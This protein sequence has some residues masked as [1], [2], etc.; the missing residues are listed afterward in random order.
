MSTIEKRSSVPAVNCD[1]N[2][3]QDQIAHPD[4][5]NKLAKPSKL[6]FFYTFLLFL[7]YVLLGLDISI[8]GI[9]L[10]TLAQNIGISIE[11]VSTTLI[12]RGI[13]FLSG[14]IVSGFL[15]GK[16]NDFIIII[17]SLLIKSLGLAL[18]PI[19]FGTS[20]LLIFTTIY[21][22]GMG[23]FET[24]GNVYCIRLW[25]KQVDPYLQFLH[26]GFC[27]GSILTPVLA[28]PFINDASHSNTRNNSSL[29]EVEKVVYINGTK[30]PYVT[31][32]FMALS[33]FGIIL[34]LVFCVT[35]CYCNE[36]S[37]K[38]VKK[39]AT[40]KDENKSLKRIMLILLFVFFFIYNGIEMSF[41]SFF[42]SF[43]LEK[44]PGLHYSK[45]EASNIC[46]LFFSFVLIGQFAAIFLS[47]R[48]SSTV[49]ILVDV[50]GLVT[51]SVIMVL[52]PFY[53][54]VA[55]WIFWVGVV[56]AGLHTA[57]LYGTTFLWAEQ[58][59]VIDGRYDK[60]CRIMTF[61]FFC[62][63]RS[64]SVFIVGGSLGEIFLPIPIGQL[65]SKSPSYFLIVL[66]VY[67]FT[68]FFNLLIMFVVSW[69]FKKRTL[70]VEE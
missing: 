10:P 59:L 9:C 66:A 62:I 50:I 28:K 1:E 68:L 27:L 38:K 65:I 37:E 41:I 43:A 57:S 19:P 63:L 67:S 44:S 26:F 21:S 2:L 49:I 47:K 24:I 53:R 31:S 46:I 61:I 23:I 40:K 11:T 25:G 60:V 33:A 18:V 6:K 5:T 51:S 55:I 56:W 8:L 4:T 70:Q 17:F 48:F 45:E 34:F 30:L 32:A 64:V 12:M 22:F 52:L 35:Y 39:T 3:L 42:F 13:G 16:V 36:I 69:K 14:S 20:F 7:G 29:T 54:H 15:D 58:Y